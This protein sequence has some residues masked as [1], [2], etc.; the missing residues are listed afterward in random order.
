MNRR[1]KIIRPP[2]ICA[3][4]RRG[5][6]ARALAVVRRVAV[7]SNDVVCIHGGSFDVNSASLEG[8]RE[9]A[10]FSSGD[11]VRGYGFGHCA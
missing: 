11:A 2:P 7:E 1:I 6:P 5:D 10:E 3:I 9:L 4:R 8:I